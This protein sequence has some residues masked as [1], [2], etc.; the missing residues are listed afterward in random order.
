MS[1]LEPPMPRPRLKVTRAFQKTWWRIT[2]GLT[3]FGL[4]IGG[5]MGYHWIAESYR[6]TVPEVLLVDLPN[7]SH[8]PFLLPFRIHN[9]G[10]FFSIEN[11]EWTC[12]L[13]ELKAG[14]KASYEHI[15]A[16]NG[17]RESIAPNDDANCQCWSVDTSQ[18]QV[19]DI[20][21][22]KMHVRVDF[23][24]LWLWRRSYQSKPFTWQT[25]AIPPRWVEG[26]IE[27]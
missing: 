26:K 27:N 14:V 8:S 7:N 2:A 9:R 3:V 10:S 25:D 19:A 16:S 18:F 12:V 22:A 15:P 1:E 11:V 23:T 21:S 20:Q 17:T 5:L 24:T 4:L 13:D 6:A